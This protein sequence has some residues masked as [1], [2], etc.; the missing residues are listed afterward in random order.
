[1]G[2]FAVGNYTVQS[3]G[4]MGPIKVLGTREN[5]SLNTYHLLQNCGATQNY[6]LMIISLRLFVAVQHPTGFLSRDQVSFRSHNAMSDLSLSAHP[7]LI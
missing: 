6:C 2:L 5:R 1:M 3:D 4:N 7:H